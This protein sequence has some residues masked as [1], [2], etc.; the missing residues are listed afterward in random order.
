MLCDVLSLLMNVTWAPRVTM[1]SFGLATPLAM[2]MVVV[3]TA[4]AGVVAGLVGGRARRGRT[5]TRIELP[6]AAMATAAAAE[7]G[8]R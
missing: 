2:L 1:M 3:R 5:G 4:V 8:G 6:H 7:R